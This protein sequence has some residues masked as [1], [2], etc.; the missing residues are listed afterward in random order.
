V[1]AEIT[2]T[3][4]PAGEDEAAE[5]EAVCELVVQSN[6]QWMERHIADGYEV[7]CCAKCAGVRYVPPTKAD[8]R[9]GRIRVD[10]AQQLLA[11]KRGACGSVAAYDAAAARTE[12]KEAWVVIVP[13]GGSYYHA[14]VGTNDGTYDPTAKMA[15]GGS[16]CACL[17]A[18]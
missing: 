18:S 9:L 6:T 8:Y 13:Q 15:L 1:S 14:I 17:Q 3:L 2:I 4:S 12:G 10:G 7:P 5:L 16:T 11:T